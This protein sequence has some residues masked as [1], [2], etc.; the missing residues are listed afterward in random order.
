MILRAVLIWLLMAVLAVLNGITRNAL[1]T[2]RAGDHA[3]HVFSTFTLCAVLFLVALA[4][5]RWV[6]PD[7]ARQALAIGV[8]WLAMTIAFEFVAGHYLFGNSWAKLFA[9]YNLM[10]GRIWVLVLVTTLLSPW[11]AA[12]LRGI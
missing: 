10:R 8:L 12:R 4:T 5:I 6:G 1:I 9:D 7:S 3:A 11:L 2:P